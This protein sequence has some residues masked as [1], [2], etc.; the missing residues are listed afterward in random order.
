[1]AFKG[2]GKF[3]PKPIKPIFISNIIEGRHFCLKV[4]L[5]ASFTNITVNGN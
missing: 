4:T 3:L 2:E 1:M 5:N